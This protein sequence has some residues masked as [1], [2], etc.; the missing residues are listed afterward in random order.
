MNNP[1]WFWFNSISVL[2]AGFR[3]SVESLLDDIKDTAHADGTEEVLEGEEGVGDAE[4]Q[5]GELE[6]DKEDHDAKVDESVRGGDQVRLLVNNKRERGQK[7]GLGRAEIKVTIKF[8]G[9]ESS[10][11]LT[12]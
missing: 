4:E 1:T 9:D 10:W 7:T 3:L 6:I 8:F 2:L 5:W 11:M 12:S